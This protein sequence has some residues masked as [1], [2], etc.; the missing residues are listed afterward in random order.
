MS[1]WLR[2][3]AAAKYS[4]ISE[5]TIRTWMKEGMRHSRIGHTV[6]IRSDWID[7][8]LQE[9]EDRSQSEIDAIVNEF[10]KK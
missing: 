7:E 3:K 6:L 2:I 1:E 5:R 8:Y 9:H 4:K 10:C